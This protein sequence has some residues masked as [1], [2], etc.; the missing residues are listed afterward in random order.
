MSEVPK[1]GHSKNAVGRRKSAN[2]RKYK[3]AKVRKG[4]LPRKNFKQPGLKQP[5]LGTPNLDKFPLAHPKEKE[6]GSLSGGLQT[7]YGFDSFEY[8]SHSVRVQFGLVLS[9]VWLG[10]EYGFVTLLTENA[11]E[12][13]TQNSTRTAP[14]FDSL[15]RPRER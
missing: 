6:W 12:N 7:S 11:P 15:L 4:A 3:S 14:R 5:R 10:S 1:R 2:E 9:T 13:H 8:G